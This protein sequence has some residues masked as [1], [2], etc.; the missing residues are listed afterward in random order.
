MVCQGMKTN[1]QVQRF[2]AKKRKELAEK[3]GKGELSVKDFTLAE[4]NVIRNQP[5]DVSRVEVLEDEVS[6]DN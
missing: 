1:R 3:H 4:A 5:L 2:K 6:P